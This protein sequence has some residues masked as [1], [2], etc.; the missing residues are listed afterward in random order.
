V[1]SN[2]RERDVVRRITMGGRGLIGVVGLVLFI[3][4]PAAFATTTTTSDAQGEAA[5]VNG[6]AGDD[7]ITITVFPAVGPEDPDILRVED[8]AGVTAG[9]VGCIQVNPNRADCNVRGIADVFGDA[10]NDTI[11]FSYSAGALFGIELLSIDGGDGNDRI[12]GSEK[13]DSFISGGLGDDNIDGRGG[14]D[15]IDCGPGNDTAVPDPIDFAQTGCENTGGGSVPPLLTAVRQAS[16]AVSASWTLPTGTESWDF[17]VATSPAT[18][19][20]GYFVDLAAFPDPFLQRGD[21]SGTATP[22]LPPGTYYV[23]VIGTPT[24]DICEANIDDLACVFQFSNVLTVTVPAPPPPPPPPP[25]PAAAAAADKVLTLGA[26]TAS[27]SQDVDKLS[28]T[29]NPGEV[30]K[31]DLSGSVSVPGASKVYRF[32]TVKKSIGAGKTKLTL[33]LP[34]KGKK[35]VK[36]A[37]K[38][39][40]KLKAKLKLVVTDGAGNS[41]TSKHTVRLKP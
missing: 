20:L 3:W 31:V 1:G 30:V 40:K 36:R 19:S 35:A 15:N 32:K 26:V 10:G 23:H 5:A 28:I 14:V 7:V 34:A 11:T 13:H 25:P 24:W 17:E 22:S 12:T 4:A 27:S 6:S 2:T 37:L 39:K 29:L 33:K 21:T 38:R 41:K 9:P 18:D 8:P 16:G